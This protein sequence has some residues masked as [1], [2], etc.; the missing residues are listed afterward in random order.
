MSF[1]KKLFGE[2]N[3]PP[4]SLAVSGPSGVQSMHPNLQRRFARGIQYN[5]ML[6]ITFKSFILIIPLCKS[7]KF[8][9]VI[10]CSET[11]YTR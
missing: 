2:G 3:A 4:S 11:S 10:F 5:S 8:R 1:F 6:M 7:F 9:L